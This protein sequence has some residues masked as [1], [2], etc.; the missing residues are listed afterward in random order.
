MSKSLLDISNEQA[1]LRQQIELIASQNEGEVP[2]DLLDAL[3]QNQ[4]DTTD[5]L[6]GYLDYM[7]SIDSTVAIC[8]DKIKGF[9]AK[10][11]QIEAIEKRMRFNLQKYM[12]DNNVHQ[13]KCDRTISLSSLKDKIE[14]DMDLLPDEYKVGTIVYTPAQDVIDFAIA[15]GIE[16][17]GVSIITDRL[18]LRIR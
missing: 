10:I 4:L 7:S 9:N 13:I 18:S 2:D 8:K 14:I 3:A 12:T 1:E 5:K 6:N 15:G 17:A 16:I 11:K